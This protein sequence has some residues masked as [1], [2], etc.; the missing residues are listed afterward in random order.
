MKKAR[1]IR[2]IAVR[3]ENIFYYGFDDLTTDDRIQIREALDD[4]KKLA[5]ELEQKDEE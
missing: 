4:L 3:L 2:S 1:D 5:D